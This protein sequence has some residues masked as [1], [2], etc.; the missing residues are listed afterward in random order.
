[1][2]ISLRDVAM[3]CQL[4]AS[5]LCLFCRVPTSYVVVDRPVLVFM[6]VHLLVGKGSTFAWGPPRKSHGLVDAHAVHVFAQADPGIWSHFV[7]K[8]NKLM[9]LPGM[10]QQR[11]QIAHGTCSPV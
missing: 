11:E 5:F 6:L 10:S 4:S 8:G 1:M 9:W 7:D 3:F 2:A